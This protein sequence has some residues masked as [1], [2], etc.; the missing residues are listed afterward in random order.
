MRAEAWVWIVCWRLGRVSI[1]FGE[2]SLHFKF[3][4][5]KFHPF[6]FL[7]VNSAMV[8]Q[9]MRAETWVWIVC[10]GVKRHVDSPL[11]QS[12]L[13]LCLSE[14]L[15]A[16]SQHCHG[17]S[18]HGT[19]WEP[20]HSDILSQRVFTCWSPFPVSLQWLPCH[21]SRQITSWDWK[22]TYLGFMG[23]AF[24]WVKQRQFKIIIQR[25]EFSWRGQE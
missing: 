19:E 2:C 5:W 12:V 8:D 14:C 4:T 23:W 18:A 24:F 10:R 9:L 21:A 6:K 13:Y 17:R 15:L 22:R 1:F 16:V 25:V 20:G 3:Q 7:G 11:Q